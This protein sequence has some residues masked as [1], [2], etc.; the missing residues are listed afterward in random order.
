MPKDVGRTVVI[1]PSDVGR[2]M[3]VHRSYAVHEGLTNLR[4]KSSLSRLRGEVLSPL[5]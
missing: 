4:A 5:E 3:Q 2:K 1:A